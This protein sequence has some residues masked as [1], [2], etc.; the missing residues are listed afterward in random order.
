MA[1]DV[2]PSEIRDFL[3]EHPPFDALPREE[4]DALPAQL[5]ME[6]YRRG[7]HILAMGRENH[8]LY[9]V[10]AGAVDI[11]DEAGTLV[12]RGEAGTCFGSISLL[13]ANPSTFVV[14]TIED[15]LTL[16]MD[17][18]TFFRLRRQ[19]ADFEHF[20][21]EQRAHRMRAAVGRQQLSANGNAI[22]KTHARALLTRDLITMPTGASIR[23]TAEA[24]SRA[25]ES[26]L[27]IMDSERLVGI[28]TDRD[29]RSRVVAA[30]LDPQ[31]PVGEIMT[32]HPVTGGTEMLAFEIL[33]EMVGR[34]IH[35]LP[36]LEGG[37]PVGIVTTTD[38]MRI[39][40]AN[41]VYVVGDIS[42]Q[43]DVDGIAKVTGR[44][45]S[46]VESLVSQ[47][48]SAD[49][50]GRIVTAIGDAVERRLLTL[51]E[52]QLG[53]PPVPFCWVSL[54]SRAR[55]EQAL[56]SDQ[57][58]ALILADEVQPE[59]AAYFETLA[60]E[61]TDGLLQCGYPPCPGDVMATNP[62]WR[63]PLAGW[64]SEF[65]T[66]MNHPVPDAILRASIFFDMR[67]VHGDLQLY[68]ALQEQVLTDAPGAKRF[69]AQ[70]AKGAVEKEPPLGFFRGLVVERHGE[71]KDHL[72]IK[73]GG[74]GAVVELA[75]MLALTIGSPE[76]N[77]QARI[78]AAVA[79][80]LLS[81]ERGDNL[82]DAFEFISYIRLKH[83]AEQVRAGQHPDNFIAPGD[84]NSFDKR[85]LR[86]A[87]AIVRS[88]Q[89][90]IAH[91]YPLSY[92]S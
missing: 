29:L 21:D 55:L 85:H 60:R 72:E 54:G 43:R 46:V 70:L 77:T 19:H 20:F 48:A 45:G 66:W 47:D 49:N 58:N 16:V 64:R 78:A 26:S 71:H 22:L 23:D 17:R 25:N 42:R 69:H 33:L 76:V 57:D 28:V 4:L 91:S 18:D 39:E 68:A 90:A 13:G 40:Q 82:R 14:T 27:L 1:L 32:R 30:G 67:P 34:N 62:R 37:K 56:A 8:H 5:T 87:F 63:Q 50:I 6:Y 2:E 52:E 11:F 79:G 80:G 38:L 31:R 86:A 92:I 53:P 51:A 89:S 24:M 9:I 65:R 36:I 83:Q 59:H 61:V 74:V 7:S 88:A 35:H 15:T 41:P 81:E 10:S 84:L 75:R 73:R 44:L 12:D 3:A